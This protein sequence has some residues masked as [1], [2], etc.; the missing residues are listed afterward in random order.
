MLHNNFR[1]GDPAVDTVDVNTPRCTVIRVTET[2]WDYI[3]DFH[4]APEKGR[5]NYY[6]R[7]K[8]KWF[9]MDI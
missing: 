3:R 2:D 8:I 7:W 6:L 9:G 1:V 5:V 4:D